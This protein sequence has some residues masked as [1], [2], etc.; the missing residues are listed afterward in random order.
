MSPKPFDR[1]I[2]HLDLDSFFISV[3]RLKDSS[4]NGIPVI[5][6]GRSRRSVVA[7]CSYEA[8]KY[9]VKSAMPI[10][11]ALRLCPEALV[12]KGDMSSYS[13]YSKM[14]TDVIAS[15]APLFEK[16]SIDEFFCD[17]SGMD[18]YI[19]CWKWSQELREKIIQE[20]GLPISFGL[21][22]NKLVSK[23][24]TGE[25]KPNG[26]LLIAHGD[27]RDF[28]APLSVRKIPGLGRS[29]H[30]CLSLMGVHTIKTLSEIPVNVLQRHFGKNG[31]RLH[32]C[33]HGID[34]RPVVNYREHKSISTE[35]T[36]QKDSNDVLFLK[37]TVVRL[38]GKLGFQL[39]QKGQLT[40]CV[41]IKIRYADFST[42]TKQRRISYTA[43]DQNLLTVAIELFSKLYTK[44]R[45]I[46]LIGVKLSGLV[47]GSTQINLF[48]DTIKETNL[49]HALDQIKVRY[50]TNAIKRARGL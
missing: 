46:R 6:G 12:V 26:K 35:R 27:E 5:V 7:S 2:L 21:S 19:G 48:E 8:R 47:R 16:S 14:V 24:G 23:V 33:A 40:S 45:M 9:G 11:S 1:A 28:L 25:A 10:H 44:Y 49:L 50:G 18:K 43:N 42:H 32:E 22:V 37:D 3:E 41:T 29:T 17:L 30:Q 4:L 34:H 31:V 38:I 20:T 36:F 15:E 39:R 13:H